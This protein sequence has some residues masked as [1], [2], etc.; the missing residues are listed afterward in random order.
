MRHVLSLKRPGD[1]QSSSGPQTALYFT[2]EMFVLCYRGKTRFVDSRHAWLPGNC[3]FEKFEPYHPRVK[4]VENLLFKKPAGCITPRIVSL[5]FNL[6]RGS[7]DLPMF[8][9]VGRIKNL[10]ALL[11][12]VSRGLWRPHLSSQARW[13]CLRLRCGCKT[14][15]KAA[16]AVKSPSLGWTNSSILCLYLTTKWRLPGLQCCSGCLRPD[17][18]WYY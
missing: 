15:F 12:V 9:V 5:S 1:S 11:I 4:R 16:L 17:D 7:Q 13:S 10:A 18:L 14:R 6:A 2:L 8:A 3:V